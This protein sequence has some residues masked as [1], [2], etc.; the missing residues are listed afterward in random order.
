M[1]AGTAEVQ[2]WLSRH[3]NLYRW[4]GEDDRGG[5]EAHLFDKLS[6]RDDDEKFDKAW[7]GDYLFK[8]LTLPNGLQDARHL[9]TFEKTPGEPLLIDACECEVHLREHR[10]KSLDTLPSFSASSGSSPH[11]NPF[12]P[13]S[14]FS[15][16]A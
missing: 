12:N 5:G 15:G 13:L 14:F 9:Y 4:M 7:K 11:R 8:G 2:G 6:S 16:G 10:P 1:K 3:P